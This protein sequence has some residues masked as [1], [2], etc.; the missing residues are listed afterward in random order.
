MARWT[1]SRILAST[2]GAPLITRETVARDTPAAS[3]TWSIVGCCPAREGR[4][5]MA[6]VIAP[7]VFRL[8]ALSRPEPP[9][10]RR[11]P[12]AADVISRPSVRAA[13]DDDPDAVV[14][15]AGHLL[16]RPGVEEVAVHAVPVA[17]G[18]P[19]V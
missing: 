18:Q 10:R 14:H 9:G 3:A 1:I 13:L 8:R 12:A 11:A 2:L 19:E 16:D 17:G 15:P 4:V 6:S 5:V 7:G